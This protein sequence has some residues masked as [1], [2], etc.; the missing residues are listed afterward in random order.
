MKYLGLGYFDKKKNG[1]IT[2]RKSRGDH[3]EM[4]GASRGIL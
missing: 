2:E 3:A 1:R 4:S